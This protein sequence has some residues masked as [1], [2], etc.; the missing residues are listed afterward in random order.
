MLEILIHVCLQSI[1]FTKFGH[2]LKKEK[3]DIKFNIQNDF[4]QTCKNYPAHYQN[5][6]KNSLFKIYDN[7]LTNDSIIKNIL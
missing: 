3:K 7:L 4:F 5:A 1:H 6:F 2:I